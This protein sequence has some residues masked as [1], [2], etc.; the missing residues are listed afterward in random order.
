MDGNTPYGQPAV[1]SSSFNRDFE[2][3]YAGTNGKL[4]HWYYTEA[5]P[6]WFYTGAID[7]VDWIAGYPGYTQ[8]DDSFFSVVARTSWGA[9]HEVSCHSCST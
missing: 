6:G 1:F 3:V 9:L 2:L 8:T 5:R 7:T 4:Y